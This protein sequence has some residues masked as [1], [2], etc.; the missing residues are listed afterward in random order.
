MKNV[1][2]NSNVNSF[3]PYD[4]FSLYRKL[5]SVFGEPQAK[6]QQ[7][8]KKKVRGKMKIQKWLKHK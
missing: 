3:H 2:R 6:Q 5:G 1:V 7:K 4:V 8:M